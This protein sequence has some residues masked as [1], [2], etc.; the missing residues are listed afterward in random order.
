M[1]SKVRV[2]VVRVV[3][4]CAWVVG[5]APTVTCP[6]GS[7]LAADGRCIAA[8]DAGPSTD[9]GAGD[10]G[11]GD[12]NM[13]AVDAGTGPDGCALMS[14]YAD[15]DHDGHGDASAP[16]TA[17]AAPAGSV[18]SSDDCNDTCATCHPGGT[19]VCEGT[20][21]ENCDGHVDESCA[22]TNGAT[23]ACGASATAPCHMG[24]Q[25]C[26]AGAWGAC[27]GNVDPA[28]ELCDGIDNNCNGTIDEGVLTTW[29]HDVD[30][31]AHG[32]TDP[33]MTMMACTMPTGYVASSD[34]CNDAV[35]ADYP[36]NTELC[37]GIDNNCDSLPDNGSGFTCVL[38]MATTCMTM[39]GS[40]GTAIC[41]AGCHAPIG[42][43]CTPPAEVCGG[44]DENCNGIAD[45]GLG[46]VRNAVTAV[47][48]GATTAAR[49]SGTHLVPTATGY[50]VFG[51]TQE[52]PGH[53]VMQA[54]QSDG[55]P[56]GSSL[57]VPLSIVPPSSLPFS[58]RAA[59]AD[60]LIAY[61]SVAASGDITLARVNATGGIVMA[62]AALTRPAGFTGYARAVIAD[63]S[64]TLATVYASVRSS[65]TPYTYAIRR[66]RVNISGAAPGIT[67]T[68]DVVANL[69]GQV[70]FDVV[71]T[72]ARDYV[73]YIDTAGNLVLAGAPSGDATTPAAA[74][75][76]TIVPAGTS[77]PVGVAIAIGDRSMAIGAGNALGVTWQDPNTAS[78]ATTHFAE[79]RTTAPFFTVGTAIALSPAASGRAVLFPPPTWIQ[80]V[81]VPNGT[82][83]THSGYWFVASSD[84]DPSGAGGASLDHVWD[85]VGG[86]GAPSALLLTMPTPVSTSRSD[87]S[88]VVGPQGIRLAETDAAGSLV[89]R[90]VGCR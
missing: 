65:G 88:L 10:T 20:L 30:G 37:D 87:I 16:M 59:G 63:A 2:S 82:A 80:I 42:L 22:C 74:V 85:V 15:T 27:A 77:I 43:G 66:Y 34:D 4:L 26:A 28:A 45:E 64:T 39:C 84:L 55:T 72:M 76:G 58:V 83:E 17:C 81:A 12:A 89:T 52:S 11:R 61:G 68:T 86:T 69:S 47:A 9:G 35:A 48:G 21:D 62:P 8:G 50:V 23:R 71:S 5:C 53:L 25:T 75:M 90:Q 49:F 7:M 44:L 32:T 54:I 41:P 36:G 33:T 67:S 79:V 78:M 31:D 1:M 3:V 24:T 19:E 70:L 46:V 57:P 40:M 13:G 60:F 51:Q 6:A 73:A 14:Y 38:G 56:T 18:A 29:H